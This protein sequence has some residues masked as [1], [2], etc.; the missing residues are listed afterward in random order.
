MSEIISH[1]DALRKMNEINPNFTILSEFKG[2]RD[3]ILRRCN[4]CGDVREVKARSII[5]KNHGELRKCP[6]CAAYERAKFKRKTNAQFIQ[7]LYRINPNIETL[8]EYNTS[9]T[10]LKCRCKLDGYI[11]NA[12]PH[13]LLQNHGCPEC[14]RSHGEIEV[15]RV[16]DKNNIS[17]D[18][19]FTFP[20]CKN[21]IS[22]RFDFYLK[23]RN[24]CIEY[25]GRQHYM[26]VSFGSS[27][28]EEEIMSRF[29]VQCENDEI[30][31]QYCKDNGI[32]LIRIPYTDFDNIEQILN[33]YI[34]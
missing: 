32:K 20:D 18:T 27:A 34:S 29:K 30:K 28:N 16:L 11:W 17:Y 2:W 22:L 13:S 3:Y 10:Y 12:K 4:V 26:P 15:K 19:E 1:E 8:E 25:Q 31:K 33:K 24:I 21:K 6:V 14:N 5:E 7:E 9:D 23:D